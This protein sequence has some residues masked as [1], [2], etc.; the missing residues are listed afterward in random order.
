[1]LLLAISA[2]HTPM[3]FYIIIS[4]LH[5]AIS[6]GYSTNVKIQ[7][8]SICASIK[9]QCTKKNTAARQTVLTDPK[10]KV[11]YAWIIFTMIIIIVLPV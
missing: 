9:I 8:K 10:C 4:I 1:M 11:H 2:K 5:Y 6:N 3:S 7:Q